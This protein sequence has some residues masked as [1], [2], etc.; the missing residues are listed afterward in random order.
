ME[1]L[2][3]KRARSEGKTKTKKREKMA[4]IIEDTI[5]LENKLKL[6]IEENSFLKK[7][8]LDLRKKL[9]NLD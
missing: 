2:L 1:K 8:I 5:N 4:S 6:K 7:N 3:K 9:N